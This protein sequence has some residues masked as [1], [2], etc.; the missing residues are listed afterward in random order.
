METK[1][2]TYTITDSI[3]YFLAHD[4]EV[5]QHFGMNKYDKSVLRDDFA[6]LSNEGGISESLPIK[7]DYYALALCL[8][9]S[10]VK[11]TG[12]FTFTVTPGSIHLTSPKY[13]HSFKDASDDL[14]MYVVLFK[15][16]FLDDSFIKEAVLDRL[17][18]MNPD[19][20]PIYQLKEESFLKLKNIYESLDHEIKQQ[21]DFAFPIVKLELIRL[22]YEMRRACEDCK[23][24]S[25]RQLSR[26][27]QLAHRFQQEVEEEYIEKRTVQ[28]YAL[29]LNVSA[30]HLSEVVKQ[31]TGST[32]LHIIHRRLY[33]EAKH[34]LHYSELSI[35]E[36]ADRLNFDT[37][38]H[39]SRFFKQFA[40]YNPSDLK[41]GAK[42]VL[43]SDR[44][45][46]SVMAEEDSF[47]QATGTFG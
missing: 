4:K 37:S 30:K 7:T 16:E 14:M 25:S 18:E 22:F 23:C 27:Y 21:D 45:E 2:K 3:E 41:R 9:G 26:S 40:G 28:E 46:L 8:Q 47:A 5:Q 24:D 32:A 19:E 29:S 43:Y 13:L 31:E 15:K 38:S 1:N 44:F 33:R 34:L 10:V 17:L 12:H 20:A 11:T 42:S 39:F 35:K 6:L 36:I